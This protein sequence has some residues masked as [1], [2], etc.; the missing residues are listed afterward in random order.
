[1]NDTSWSD[2][3]H[4][5]TR[6]SP[7]ATVYLE[8]NQGIAFLVEHTTVMYFLKPV[9]MQIMINLY[10]DT[11]SQGYGPMK[12]QLIWLVGLL[13]WIRMTASFIT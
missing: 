7:N 4:D 11:Y 1:M 5:T 12:K 3:S 9:K 10:R 2:Q 13:V 8:R 6:S